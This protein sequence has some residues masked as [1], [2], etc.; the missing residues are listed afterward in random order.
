ME[1]PYIW[2]FC[3]SCYLLQYI[4]FWPLPTSLPLPWSN[5]LPLAAGLA[6]ATE[7]VSCF[8]PRST[9]IYLQHISQS[10]AVFLC[11]NPPMDS[12]CKYPWWPCNAYLAL[13][14]LWSS[15]E[16]EVALIQPHVLASSPLMSPLQLQRPFCASKLIGHILNHPVVFTL[17]FSV[18]RTL[19]WL[20]TFTQ[21]SPAELP[22]PRGLLWLP[23]HNSNTFA[24]T[25]F[26]PCALFSASL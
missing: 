3:K 11:S 14:E 17:M 21:V 1:V 2:S 8:Y 22:Y 15:S 12:V 9:T 25:P 23:V 20:P 18:P 6:V 24:T 13:L 26:I 4:R 7:L 10:D 19:D 16:E 5:P